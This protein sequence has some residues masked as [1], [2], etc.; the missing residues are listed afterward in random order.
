M[1]LRLGATWIL[2]VAVFTVTLAYG[3]QLPLLP[4]LL[5][6]QVGSPAAVSWHTGAL[7]GTYTLALFLFAPL[8]GLV[9]DRWQRKAVIVVG[10][11]GFALALTV[12]AFIDHL[13]ALYLGRFLTGAFSAAV[14]PVS[15]ALVADLSS[16]EDWRARRFAWLNIAGIAGFLVGPVVGGVLGTMWSGAMPASGAPFLFIAGGAAAASLLAAILLP[17]AASRRAVEK[18]APDPRGRQQLR[19]L[20]LISLLLAVGL[21]TF[22]VG[23]ALVGKQELGLT[24]GQIGLMFAECMVAMAVAQVLVFNPWFPP[25][26]TRWLLAPAFGVLATGLLLV[27]AATSGAQLFWGVAAIAGA[28]GVLSP[29]TG[30]WVSL[31][32]GRAQ[33][34]ELGLQT[35]ISSL[36]QT[37]GAAIAGLL[38]GN[39]GLGERAF[40][41]AAAG[42]VAGAAL[43]L[44]LALSLTRSR[45]RSP[46]T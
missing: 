17:S 21:G 20:L 11:A 33:G 9:S 41:L 26:A 35:A 43:S 32:A 8:W 5:E 13:A 45:P 12:F 34:S 14:L 24:P 6:R 3:V 7:T 22:E 23:L 25:R 38:Y 1:A 28:A 39:A 42:A 40:L 19:R 30:F 4:S 2:L 31:M 46:A 16:D 27:P 44:P 29:V 37:I 10:L 18:A 36:G 15:Q